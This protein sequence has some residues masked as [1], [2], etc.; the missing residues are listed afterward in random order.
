M[1]QI[2]I[3]D[4]AKVTE[5]KKVKRAIKYFCPQD[6]SDYEKLYEDIKTYRKRKHKDAT[7]YITLQVCGFVDNLKTANEDNFY[8]IQTD[9]YSMSFR[10]W[11]LLA[12]IPIHKD[13]LRYYLFEDILAHFLW[14]ITFYGPE[15]KM[16]SLAKD[17]RKT[18]KEIIKNELRKKNEKK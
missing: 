6:K 1:K 4:I 12:S 5:W 8:T 14:E 15:K 9:K 17:L 2:T 18:Q 3:I 16:N 13:T 7:E 11:K 10:S